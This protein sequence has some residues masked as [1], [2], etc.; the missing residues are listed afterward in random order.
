MQIQRAVSN[1]FAQ[2]SDA[3][4]QLSPAQ[5]RQPCTHLNH[6]TVG[7]HVR[8]T[9]ELFQCLEA[10]YE[11][12]TVN[13][14]QRKRDI[15]I[16]SDPALAMELLDRIQQGLNREDKDLLLQA[17]YD[18]P[19]GNI[20]EF[21]TNYLREL[22][23]NLEHTIHHMALIR[24]GLREVSDIVLPE[25]FGVASSTVKYRQQCAQ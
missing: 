22:A 25:S 14:E 2:L 5:F 1:V 21:R 6:N 13:Y 9:I 12:G 18:A 8:H 11:S 19:S 23:Y 20:V 4:R 3:I 10:G 16:E 15:R 17:C 7:Q 24:V